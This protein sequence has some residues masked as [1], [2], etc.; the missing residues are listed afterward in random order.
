MAEEDK[1]VIILKVCFI[2]IIL[3]VTFIAGIIPQKWK[4]CRKN[5]EILSIAN[6]FSGG[7]FLAIAFVHLIPETTILY[8]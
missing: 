4:K 6:T 7:V 3:I 8:Y 1:S 2:F 5:E